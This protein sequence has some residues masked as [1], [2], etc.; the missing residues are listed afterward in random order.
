MTNDLVR[1]QVHAIVARIA[2]PSRI[3]TDLGP[4]TPLGE[5]GFWLDSVDV[6]EVMIACEQAFGVSFEG[7][8]DLRPETLSTVGA[9]GDAILK[10]IG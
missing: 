10:R 7:G 8:V 4:D 1:E 6:L 9:L 5:G 2:G 3:P